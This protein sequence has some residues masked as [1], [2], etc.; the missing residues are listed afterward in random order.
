MFQCTLLFLFSGPQY[1]PPG[2]AQAY[3][4]MAA[5]GW[6]KP[7]PGVVSPPPYTPP[8][9]TPQAAPVALSEEQ[10]ASAPPME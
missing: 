9:Y 1:P 4:Q 6:T 10:K 7:N 3:P 5:G 2:P 8:P